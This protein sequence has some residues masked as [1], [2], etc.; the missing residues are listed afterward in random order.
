M[1]GS[2]V[3]GAV[4]GAGVYEYAE[5]GLSSDDYALA[6]ALSNDVSVISKTQDE[7]EGGNLKKKTDEIAETV[8]N[9]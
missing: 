3:E 5:I 1:L 6:E 4:P 7:N 8:E 2:N 9:A